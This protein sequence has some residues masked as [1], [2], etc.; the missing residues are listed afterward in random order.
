LPRAV[1]VLGVLCISSEYS[2]GMIRASLIAVPRRGR[3][4]AAKSLVFAAVTFVDLV[5]QPDKLALHPPVPPRRVLRRDS[6]HELP[7]RGGRGRPP[8][9]PTARVVP[10]ARDQPTVPGEQR[11]RRHREDLAPP[12]AGS[13]SR[14]QCREPQPV[15]RLVTKPPT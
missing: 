7:D 3:V 10:L 12:V 4:L 9:T 8:W 11:R 14:Q 6:D 1:A 15:G 5:A 2:S 13:Q